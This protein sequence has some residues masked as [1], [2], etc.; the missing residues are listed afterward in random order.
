MKKII[1]LIQFPWKLLV[2][3]LLA[4]ITYSYAMFQGGFV[5]WFLFFSFSPFVILSLGVSFYP[6]KDIEVE[7]ILTKT[8]YHAGE[9]LKVKIMLKRKWR[10]PLFYLIVED[11]LTDKL[12]YSPQVKKSKVILTPG[13][14]REFAFEYIVENL[15]R[16]EHFFNEVH[17]K[18][19]D[20]LGLIEK[21]ITRPVVNQIIV[22]PAFTEM[23]Y[24]PFENHYDQG[25]TASRERVQRDT[26]IAIGV[27]EYE[28][29]DRFSWINWKAT[30]KRNAIMTKEFEQRQS[31]DVLVV[32][33]GVR[34]S[35]FELVVSFTASI[36]R[37]ILR[38][39]A[40]VGLL[41]YGKER[42]SFAIRG[43]EA[44]QHQ[45]F[46]HLAKLEDSSTIT[47]DRAL[48]FEGFLTQQNASLLLV[49]AELNK[50]LLEKVGFLAQRKGTIVIFLMK[51][52]KESLS[53]NE[54]SLRSTASSRGIRIVMVHEG[55]FAN[56][57]AE[58]NRG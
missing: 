44:Q 33:D 28:P 53:A 17:L 14:K 26:T 23:I 24:R 42:T 25:M 7:R 43:G 20:L 31:H 32:M 5:S 30:A 13:F 27:R 35:H 12:K 15:P 46:Y 51:K 22:Y 1:A 16:G 40:Q 11:A 48:E 29:G 21:E 6:L 8:D 39:G 47:L 41:T 34:H 10:F 4:V 56:A 49:T 55:Q 38:K 19:G 3:L 36:V 37:A 9:P 54:L 52:A 58:V 45:I 57:F 18:T 2:L 50:P